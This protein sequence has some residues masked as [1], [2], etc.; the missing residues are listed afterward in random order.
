MET[1]R[2]EVPGEKDGAAVLDVELQSEVLPLNHA[3][4]L[5][6]RDEPGGDRMPGKKVITTRPM[7]LAQYLE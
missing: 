2:S 1:H 4:V 7:S 6:P 5:R 3:G